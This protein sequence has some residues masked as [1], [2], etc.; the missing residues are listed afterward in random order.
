[1]IASI[2][3]QDLYSFTIGQIV[4]D[5]Y[6][7]VN[8][9]YVFKDRNNLVFEDSFLKYLK[10]AIWQ[11]ASIRMLP[12][13]AR[14]LNSKCSFLS[15]KYI[16]FLNNYRFDPHQVNCVIDDGHLK[17]DIEGPWHETIFWEVPLL[18]IVSQ[19]YYEHVDTNWSFD[20]DQEKKLVDKRKILETNNIKFA[21]FGTRRRRSFHTQYRVVKEMVNSSNF[22][23][24]SNVRLAMMLQTTPVGTM[25]HQWIMGVSALESLAHA[26][27]Y[28]MKIYEEE[29]RG[30]TKFFLA[31]TFGTNVFLRGLTR[32]YAQR[33]MG[34]RQDS[35]D[36][37]HFA[38][39]VVIRYKELQLSDEE[40]SRKTI[41]F[42]DGLTPE[43]TIPIKQHCD[44]LGIGSIFGIGTNFTNDYPSPP[45]NIVIKL[46]SITRNSVTTPVVKLSD[47][48]TK[49]TGDKD[50]LRVA[51][52]TFYNK[53]LDKE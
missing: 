15:P 39:K 53:P 14:F 3:D 24:T 27:R 46:N 33:W 5:R 32:E 47:V 16:D 51:M 30:E 40:I 23:G 28:A 36:P 44:S 17:I 18:A 19:C 29:Y 38:E 35:G 8:A 25:S 10:E 4:F 1:M 37:L 9:T 52:W 50:A 22:I 45:L 21:D 48:L 11:M 13:E 6:R 42:S 7:D 26:N 41:M 2:L 49:A 34:V 43:R 12:E 20:S 31:D